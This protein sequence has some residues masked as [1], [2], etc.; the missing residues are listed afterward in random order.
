[1]KFTST[2]ITDEL[3]AILRGKRC[4]V[5]SGSQEGL[6]GRIEQ[7]GRFWQGKSAKIMTI[8]KLG[9]GG[10]SVEAADDVLV[11]E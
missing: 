2:T 11:L 10:L 3:T 4:V 9:R 5:T 1:M 7:V 8:V 6:E